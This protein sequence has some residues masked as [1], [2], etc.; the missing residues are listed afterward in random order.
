MQRTNP[1]IELEKPVISRD[2]EEIG[3]V[4]G[5]IVDRDSMTISE[6]LIK[7]GTFISTERIV[8]I[9]LITR[10]D[11]DGAIHLSVDSDDVDNLP[12]FVEDRYVAPGD[13]EIETMPQGWVSG[14]GGGVLF[15]GPAGP[16]R[17]EPGQGTMFEPASPN[18]TPREPDPLVTEHE[19]IIEHGMNV[20]DRNDDSLGTVE[21]VL[22]DAGDKITGFRV[23]GGW[24]SNDVIIRMNMVDTIHSDGVKLSVTADEARSAGSVE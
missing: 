5:L 13:H 24:F 21:E 10:V 22:Y 1:H 7:E 2:G 16:A 4:D 19:A 9:A 8:E 15:W 11:D 14:A 3:K 17:G 20:V 12:P 6:F 18:P 23:D